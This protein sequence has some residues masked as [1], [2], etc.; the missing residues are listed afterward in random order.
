MTKKSSNKTVFE[1][2]LIKYSKYMH[3][4]RSRYVKLIQ[5][6]DKKQKYTV[7][8]M[9]TF[10]RGKNDFSKNLSQNLY[11]TPSFE[12]NRFHLLIQ[13]NNTQDT[14]AQDLSLA[15]EQIEIYDIY[16]VQEYYGVL[17]KSKDN[18]HFLV[19]DMFVFKAANFQERLRWMKKIIS[20]CYEINPCAIEN[21]NDNKNNVITLNGDN[22][23]AFDYN[24]KF[25]DY[26]CSKS[27]IKGR[28]VP[29]IIE[30]CDKNIAVF[31][32]NC[33]NRSFDTKLLQNFILTITNCTYDKNH[34]RMSCQF[35]EHI[36][37][38]FIYPQNCTFTQQNTTTMVSDFIVDDITQKLKTQ[39]QFIRSQKIR[40]KL[41][42]FKFKYDK[43]LL[44][45]LIIKTNIKLVTTYYHTIV[46]NINSNGNNNSDLSELKEEEEEEIINTKNDSTRL[47]NVTIFLCKNNK[48]LCSTIYYQNNCCTSI[49][50]TKNV[51]AQHIFAQK[52]CNN[53]Y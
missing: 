41:K 46:N 33:A 50:I 7:K 8:T 42:D 19:N 36:V 31:Y 51:C 37:K 22:N 48:Y 20:E 30:N 27:D 3:A 28:L 23:I 17:N 39:S 34:A 53:K 11:S 26:T 15:T 40:L 6:Y 2:W 12:K 10:K 43:M 35:I 16:N 5:S 47:A 13:P 38:S 29:Y 21:S 24:I 1:G 45:S 49:K 52:N 4:P 44:D 14:G 25:V 18:C 32:V 9:Y